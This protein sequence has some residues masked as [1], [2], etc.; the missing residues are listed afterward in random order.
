VATVLVEGE[1]DRRALLTLAPRLG[2]PTPEITVL[3][4]ITNLRKHLAGPDRAPVLLLHDRGESA[5]VVRVLT[6]SPP[7]VRRF[8]CDLDLEDEL[9]R[10][11]GVPGVLAV[12][13]ARG[14]R[15]AYDR[16]AQQPAQRGR[17]DAQRL[18]RWLGARSGHKLT[19]AGYLAEA[20]P[21]G[22]VPA[23]LRDLLTASGAW[24]RDG[25]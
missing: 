14:E 8:V 19:Y 17:P 10:A 15:P 4:G 7:D 12:V 11:V 18:R 25:C 24:S 16:M 5:Y 23:P 9:I 2:V 1:S 21:L 20:V 6:D 3:D 13:E 22:S